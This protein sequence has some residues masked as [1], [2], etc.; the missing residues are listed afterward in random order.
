ME[1][2]MNSPQLME[3]T[4]VSEIRKP[5][6]DAIRLIDDSLR[7]ARLP[8][9]RYQADSGAQAIVV[10]SRSLFE[11]GG[12]IKPAL[13]EDCTE[14]LFFAP[15]TDKCALTRLPG[16]H[17]TAMGLAWAESPRADEEVSAAL[18]SSFRA[19]AV[20]AWSLRGVVEKPHEFRLYRLTPIQ[21]AHQ[22]LLD[23]PIRKLGEKAD[24]LEGRSRWFQKRHDK[25][26]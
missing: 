12:S 20:G 16:D 21:A 25:A 22:K 3:W 15:G 13:P 19:T 9:S 26:K 6:G 8:A 17:Q 1:E 10:P 23:S 24:N 11:L 5:G 14:F 4:E 18:R 2:T 7:Q